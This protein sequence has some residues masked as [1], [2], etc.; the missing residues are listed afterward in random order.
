MLGWNANQWKI[1]VITQSS[2]ALL[3]HMENNKGTVK[4]Y[5]TLVYVENAGKL[6][7][8]LWEELQG[9]KMF[10]NNN[11]WA[12]M[13][14]LNVG[15]KIEGSTV[16]GSVLSRDMMEFEDCVNNIEVEDLCSSGLHF[17][18]VQKM[19]NPNNGVL[20]KLDRVMINSRFMEVFEKANAL[21]LP[22]TVSDHS[23]V[24]LQFPNQ[25]GKVK[26]PFRFVNYIV[27]KPE[28][29]GKV[30]DEWHKGGEGCNLV[31]II[32][33]LKRLKFHMKQLNWKPGNLFVKVQSLRGKLKKIQQE[34]DLQPFNQELGKQQVQLLKEFN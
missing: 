13:G 15:L 10:V 8:K 31:H 25:D 1:I 17:N 9:H 3:C 34:L 7:R 32:A 26:K 5:C 2:Q 4:F 21:F 29:L 19:M 22:N 33:K 11:A 18:W 23:P 24:I 16:G 20:K 6:R 28:F 12:I 14:D 30:K 27:D